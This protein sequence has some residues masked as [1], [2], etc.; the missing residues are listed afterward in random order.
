MLKRLVFGARAARRT[1]PAAPTFRPRLEAVEE[2]L[3]PATFTVTTA[4]SGGTNS[5]RWAI[6]QA[7][8]AAGADTIAFAIPG[9]GVHTIRLTTALTPVTGQVTIDGA[10]QP[11]F[12]DRPVVVLEG[13]AAGAGANG[14]VLAAGSDG[15]VV[16]SLVVNQFAGNGIVVRSDGNAV[17]GCYV[18]TNPLGTK[19]RSNGLDG[20]LLEAG[21]SGNA[22]GGLP[23]GNLIAA[24]RNGVNVVGAGTDGNTVARNALVNNRGVGVRVSGGAKNNT[25]GGTTGG[26]GNTISANATDGVLINGVGTTGNTVVGNF[27]GTTAQGDA[28]AA[29]GR[30]GVAVAG[31]AT[32]NMIG[33]GATGGNL[34]SGNLRDG[35]SIR[36]A[37]TSGN[38]VRGN[39][40]GLNQPG[41]AA[42]PNGRAGVWVADGADGNTI[43]GTAAG[44]TNAIGGNKSFGVMVSGAD[45]TVIRGNRIGTKADG[46]GSVANRSHGVFVTGGSIGTKVG[47]TEA[48]AGNVIAN[49]KG[50]GVLVGTDPGAGYRTAAGAGTSILSNV[51]VSNGR[52]GIDRGANNGPNGAQ[53][54]TVTAAARVNNGTQ[55]TVTA[56]VTGAAGVVYRVEVFASTDADPSGFGEGRT[57]LGSFDVTA[58]G[59]GAVFGSGTFAYASAAG[60]KITATATNLTTGE[61]SE[62]SA[63]FTAA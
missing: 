11:G 38:T 34:I 40:V 29:N 31:G 37:G 6:N 35:V 61:T 4:S 51:I 13:V 56:A 30:D 17:H 57:L 16:K 63:V 22:I 24:S 44:E 41:A 46:T 19:A 14:L 10:T 3:A 12:T 43:G 39:F 53:P 7:N 8:A 58:S 52:L 26:T 59:A 27:I 62:F 45:Q 48:G 2:R 25:I 15:S 50:N 47:G 23:G 60:L 42:I 21:A 36:G 1:P 49:N 20:V 5:L 54:V 28:A 55:I 9:S 18:G 33:L 32:G